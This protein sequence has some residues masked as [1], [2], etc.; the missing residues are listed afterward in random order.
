MFSESWASG[1][2][3][4]PPDEAGQ[5]VHFEVVSNDNPGLFAAAPSV[6]P[7]GVLS[8]LPAPAQ[9]GSALV[10]VR[11]VDNG[12]TALGGADAFRSRHLPDQRGEHPADGQR[13][14]ALRRQ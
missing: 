13:R 10:G 5:V 3:A 7:A 11:L 2:T 6:S 4:G 1:V 8:F 14:R 9:V 12:G